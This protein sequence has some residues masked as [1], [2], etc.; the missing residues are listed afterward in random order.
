VRAIFS[1]NE[2]TPPA[3]QRTQYGLL[4]PPL[5]LNN[6]YGFWQFSLH[7]P[8]AT[9]AINDQRAAGLARG[10]NPVSMFPAMELPQFLSSNLI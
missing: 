9:P 7:C 5:D 6:W 10:A 4:A 8:F 1:I 2:D 3:L